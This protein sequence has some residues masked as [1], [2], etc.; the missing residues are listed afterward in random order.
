MRFRLASGIALSAV[1]AFVAG[2]PSRLSGATVLSDGTFSNANW[3][4]VST[5]LPGNGGTITTTQEAAGGNTGAYR[6]IQDQ[7]NAGSAAP[8][9]S[10]VFGVQ[11]NSLGTY[12]PGV[13]GAIGSISFSIDYNCAVN[14]A[15]P[16]N[17]GACVQQGMGFGLAMQQGGNIYTMNDLLLTFVPGAWTNST[18]NNLTASSFGQPSDTGNGYSTDTQHP[19][20]SASGG[21]ITFGLFNVNHAGAGAY[22]T[23]AGFD[24]WSV[25]IDQASAPEPGS[26]AL[27]SLGALA[28]GGLALRTKRR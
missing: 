2:K 28:M 5:Q 11:L 18:T 6:F 21:I 9:L 26:L 17:T 22:E 1:L 20:F 15:S 13:S 8:N 7:V 4:L 10:G 19:D 27:F 23:D 16:T 12:N 25:T 14:P 24:N 3:T